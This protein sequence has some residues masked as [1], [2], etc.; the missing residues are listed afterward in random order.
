MNK[1][2]RYKNK[3]LKLSIKERLYINKTNEQIKR[4][5][6]YEKKLYKICDHDWER[7]YSD[8]SE[9]SMFRCKKCL[10]YN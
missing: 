1:I 4:R 6:K 5:N 2:D 3:I 7:D 10:F 8:T 9:H